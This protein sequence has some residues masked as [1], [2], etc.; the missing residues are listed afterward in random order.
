MNDIKIGD[1]VEATITGIQKYGA[2][3]LV[4]DKYIGLI[5]ISEI[6]RGY[7][8]NI[9]DYIKIKDKIYAQVVGIDEENDKLKLSIKNIDYRET[10]KVINENEPQVDGFTSLKDHLDIWI[11]DKIKEIMEKM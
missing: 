5:H 3:V 4:N 11:N 10:G 6:S 9:N 1:I 7:V 2:F 8:K